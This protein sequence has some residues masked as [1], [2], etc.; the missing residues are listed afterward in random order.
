MKKYVLGIDQGTT[1]STAMVF[2]VEKQK[3][4]AHV[5]KEFPQHYPSPGYVEH[6]LNDIWG[7]VRHCIKSVL[8]E[9]AIKPT[10]IKCIGITNQRETTCVFNKLGEPLHN[11]IV[12]QDRRTHEYCHEKKDSYTHLQKKTGLPLDPYFSA[13]KLRWLLKNNNFSQPL[14]GTIDTF[15]LY[16]LTNGDSHFTESSN[17][18]RTLLMNL[19]TRQWD[20]ELLNFFEIPKEILPQIKNT[21]DDFGHTKG[22]DFLP[23][24]IAITCLFGDQ[25]SAL[26]AQAALKPGDLKCTYGTGAFLLLNTGKKIM[27][28]DHGLLSTVAYQH[29]DVCTYALEGSTYIAGAAVQ[30]LRDNFNFFKDS[31]DIENLAKKSSLKDIQDLLFLPFFTGIGSPHWKPNVKASILGMTRGTSIEDISR[32][33]LEGITFSIQDLIEAFEKDLN[34]PI[35]AIKVDGGA[36]KNKLLLEIQS[37]V[38]KKTVRRPKIIETTAFGSILGALVGLG[39]I[40]LDQIGKFSEIEQEFEGIRSNEEEA[41]YT[42]KLKTWSKVCKNFF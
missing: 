7:S 26:F 39:E 30:F 40:S 6:D 22:L 1:G 2:D 10:D 12:W 14:F 34:N 21:F 5:N 16:K 37:K 3:I 31:S 38:S 32:A 9:N 33:C 25:Q 11:A 28:S 8:K 35:S 23:D 24:G 36:V 17:A 15:L 20:D 29:N 41:Y 27:H 18:S 4:I 13:T 42:E 19:E